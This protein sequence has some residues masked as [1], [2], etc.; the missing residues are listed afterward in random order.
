MVPCD[1]SPPPQ[2]D[3][4]VHEVQGLIWPPLP[5]PASSCILHLSQH[6]PHSSSST[7]IPKQPL[8]LSLWAF[9]AQ[10]P[11]WNPLSPLPPWPSEA[12]LLPVPTGSVFCHPPSSLSAHLTA[13]SCRSSSWASCSLVPVVTSKPPGKRWALGH[14]CEMKGLCPTLGSQIWLHQAC[15][16]NHFPTPL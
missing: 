11:V 3:S 7:R 8:L 10:V 6:Q 15:M 12:N 1:P 14:L 5:P 4:P 2:E 13:S 16:T 9:N